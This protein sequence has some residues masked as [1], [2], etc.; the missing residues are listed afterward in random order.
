[1]VHG[2]D[3]PEHADIQMILRSDHIFIGPDAAT[4]KIPMNPDVL[5]F[6]DSN[7]IRIS[8][9]SQK[10]KFAALKSAFAVNLFPSPTHSSLEI[11]MSMTSSTLSTQ[12]P[13]LSPFWFNGIGVSRP[14]Q[15]TC[16]HC[17]WPTP[18]TR[19]ECE[20]RQGKKAKVVVLYQV[21]YLLIFTNHY[22]NHGN[23]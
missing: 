9:V 22:N 3:R 5:R 10:E 18:T 20:S 1:M 19:L 7:G 15:V 16:H 23:H 6:P 11:D 2:D 8:G 13:S 21:Q 17:F 12:Q 4:T 14:L